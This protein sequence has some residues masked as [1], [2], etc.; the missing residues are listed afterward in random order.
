PKIYFPVAL[1]AKKNISTP[2]V[3]IPVSIVWS[4]GIFPV[5][6]ISVMDQP[7]QAG[8]K[9]TVPD[10]IIGTGQLY[11]FHRPHQIQVV[12]KGSFYQISQ[13]RIIKKI[14]P[15]DIPNANRIS[16]SQKCPRNLWH[17]RQ[18]RE[19]NGFTGKGK[20]DYSSYT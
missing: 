9:R 16:I 19:I 7:L 18:C 15:R 11:P 14:L 4:V 8:V 12:Y 6:G 13:V 2:E 3:P 10:L 20:P 1:E 17:I 5:I